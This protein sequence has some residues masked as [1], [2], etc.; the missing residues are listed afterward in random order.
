MATFIGNVKDRFSI[1]GRGV[2]IVT[3]QTVEALVGLVKEGDPIEL[4]PANGKPVRTVIKVVEA[5]PGKDGHPFA[6]LTEMSLTKDQVATGA[7]IWVV[8]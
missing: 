3:D 7:E 8:E 1:R 6:F 4:R 5:M 2:V